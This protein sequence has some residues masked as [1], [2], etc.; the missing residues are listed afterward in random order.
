MATITMSDILAELDKANQDQQIRSGELTITD[1]LKKH[2]DSRRKAIYDFFESKIKAGVL[3]KRMVI[4]Y[5]KRCWAYSPK[6]PE[7][8]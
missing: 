7:E 6:T 2:P 3:Q 5:G 8:K 4:Q 1:Y